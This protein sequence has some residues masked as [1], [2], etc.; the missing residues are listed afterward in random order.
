MPSK[1]K[2]EKNEAAERLGK[3]IKAFGDTISDIMQDPKVREKAREF[4]DSVID[5][6]AKVASNK[7]KDEDVRE[8]FVDVGKAAQSLGKSV[9]NEFEPEKAGSETKA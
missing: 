6:A 7:V 1:E 5:A 4:S 2:V 8:K 9:V 3:L